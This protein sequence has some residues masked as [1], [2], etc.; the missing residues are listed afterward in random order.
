M[1]TWRHRQSLDLGGDLNNGWIRSW[2]IRAKFADDRTGAMAG[3][4]S[5]ERWQA[6]KQDKW[7]TVTQFGAT[8]RAESSAEGVAKSKVL[9]NLETVGRGKGDCR[10]G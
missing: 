1:Y 9:P 6:G 8:L 2:S 3:R 4:Q 10:D 7:G 5:A